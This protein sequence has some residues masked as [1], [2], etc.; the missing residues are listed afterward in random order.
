MAYG[1]GCDIVSPG[2][3]LSTFRRIVMSSS[4][5][6]SVRSPRRT[7]NRNLMAETSQAQV[8]VPG[9]VYTFL[10]TK[11]IAWAAKDMGAVCR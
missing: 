8:D 1:P 6:S 5:G 11:L 4:L 9:S 2:R 7:A 3:Q 10:P